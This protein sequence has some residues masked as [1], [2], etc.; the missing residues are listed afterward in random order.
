M[1]G[2]IESPDFFRRRRTLDGPAWRWRLAVHESAAALARLGADEITLRARRYRQL[3]KRK[4]GAR[5]ALQADSMIDMAVALNNDGDKAA[6]LKIM[7]LS[8]L[9]DDEIAKRLEIELAALATWR[10]LFFDVAGLEAA[11]DWLSVHVI[12]PE[13]RAGRGDLAVKLKLALAGGKSAARLILNAGMQIPL[14][15]FERLENY[16]MRVNLLLEKALLLTPTNGQEALKLMK[17]D[18]DYRLGEKRL[19][20]AER[21]FAETCR[22]RLQQHELAEARLRA[23]EERE[24]RRWQEI[25]R[26]RENGRRLNEARE[27]QRHEERR[28]AQALADL[29]LQARAAQDEAARQWAASSE[30]AKLAWSCSSQSQGSV[31][32]SSGKLEQLCHRAA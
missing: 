6:L 22:R 28:A 19:A 15:E 1:S 14:D 5:S 17:L 23:C 31:P 3:L 4:K 32:A 21:R 13:E 18:V 7:T 26:R 20:F 10:A 9:P 29:V 2:T 30:L 11:R 16:R 25:E 8:M 24:R 27:N 12:A